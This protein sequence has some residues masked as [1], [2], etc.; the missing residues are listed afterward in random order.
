MPGPDLL[1]GC[2]T[3]SLLLEMNFPANSGAVSCVACAKEGVNKATYPAWIF[4]G[5]GFSL[6]WKNE[7]R[8]NR[9][10]PIR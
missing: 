7:N 6:T 10:V 4:A 1:N 2:V 3:H 8:G 5:T 9:L